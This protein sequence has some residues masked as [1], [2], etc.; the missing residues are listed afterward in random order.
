MLAIVMAKDGEIAK[1]IAENLPYLDDKIAQNSRYFKWQKEIDKNDFTKKQ[2]KF[3]CVSR[4][5][6]C[7][8]F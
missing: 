4:A 1:R 2:K 3:S 7:L 5:L 6:V 8:N